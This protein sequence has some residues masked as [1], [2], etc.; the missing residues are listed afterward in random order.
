MVSSPKWSVGVITTPRDKGYYLDQTLRS[1]KNA[2]WFD[3]VIFAEPNSI[4][5][6]NFEGHVVHRRKQY[7]DWTNWASGLYE[8][9]L[10]DFESDLFLMSED[11]A[12]YQTNTRVYLEEAVTQ[13]GKF[14]SLSLYTPQRYH[15]LHYSGFHNEC[16]DWETLSTV[17]VVMTREMTISFFSSEMVQKHRFEN[18]FSDVGDIN[19]G[20]VCDPKN[21]I[22]DAV[23]G[24]WASRLNLPIY[25]HTPS[26]VQHIGHNSTIASDVVEEKN[27]CSAEDC[28]Y[29][30]KYVVRTD[31]SNH[32][33]LL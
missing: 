10:S 11:D 1:L 8:L 27:L 26:F 31:R 4:I 21:S 33:S 19:Y 17:S 28:A 13:L 29:L 7:G 2:G 24:R 16:H 22:K 12:L 15:K 25:Y 18:I 9:L 6:E 23:I 20:C 3:I 30:E 32:I 14:A 5:P